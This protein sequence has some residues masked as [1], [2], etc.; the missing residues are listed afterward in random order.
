[1]SDLVF[2][3]S[4]SSGMFTISIQGSWN[5]RVNILYICCPAFLKNIERSWEKQ[6]IIFMNGIFPGGLLQTR[7]VQR[8]SGRSH[9]VFSMWRNYASL[10]LDSHIFDFFLVDR[11][12]FA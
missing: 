12:S 10:V 2:Q 8:D 5:G 3:V 1:M 11:Q 6:D 4:L 7:Q 9:Q